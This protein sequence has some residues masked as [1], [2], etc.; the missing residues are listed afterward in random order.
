MATKKFGMPGF[1]CRLLVVLFLAPAFFAALDF[2][3]ADGAD[4][5]R[6]LMY[7]LDSLLLLLLSTPPISAV[8]NLSVAVVPVILFSCSIAATHA[9]S[10]PLTN[11]VNFPQVVVCVRTKADV[12]VLLCQ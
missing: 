5:G 6:A 2:D 9:N 12:V 11:V 8:T 4:D 10:H 7:E 1:P 3:A